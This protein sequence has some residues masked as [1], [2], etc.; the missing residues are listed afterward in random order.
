MNMLKEIIILEYK[1]KLK[2]HL[3]ICAQF[4]SLTQVWYSNNKESKTSLWIELYYIIQGKG[5]RSL[6]DN[7]T[8]EDT[9]FVKN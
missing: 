5:D 9:K 3:N 4:K 6:R 1:K 7:L 8:E 2:P